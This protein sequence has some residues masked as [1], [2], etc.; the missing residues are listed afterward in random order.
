MHL[1]CV[2][3]LS[4]HRLHL[5]PLQSYCR[6]QE[7][8]VRLCL[9]AWWYESQRLLKD[10]E[11]SHSHFHATDQAV[12]LLSNFL[13]PPDLEALRSEILVVYARHSYNH[14]PVIY[15][16]RDSCCMWVQITLIFQR[17]FLQL[18]K[19]GRLHFYWN[20]KY[21]QGRLLTNGHWD[22]PNMAREFYR[23]E[24]YLC[25][26]PLGTFGGFHFAQQLTWTPRWLATQGQLKKAE[27]TIA[28]SRSY[29]II[30]KA[31]KEH[32]NR[33]V[34]VEDGKAPERGLDCLLHQDPVPKIP[35]NV[36]PE[37][38]RTHG[39]Q[40]LLSLWCYYLS[41]EFKTVS[42]PS[43]LSTLVVHMEVYTLWRRCDLT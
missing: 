17:R 33:F 36:A 38:A 6:D 43:A 32:T 26:N 19:P 10:L 30:I 42:L 40:L 13:G 27:L 9:E 25:Q 8:I 18:H 24:F 34:Q 11:N 21:T 4:K 23:L 39:R 22:R 14:I 1:V 3:Q 31:A 29:G 7:K 15:Y 37:P 12:V 35:G 16:I 5:T 20:S 2:P 41:E 28:P